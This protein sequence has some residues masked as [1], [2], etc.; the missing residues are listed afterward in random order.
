MGSISHILAYSLIL[1]I[2]LVGAAGA[3]IPDNTTIFNSSK[4]WMVANGADSATLSLMVLNN[5]TNTI[6]FSRVEFS[7]NDPTLASLSDT[8]MVTGSDGMITTQLVGKTISGTVLVY[9]NVYYKINVSDL[10]EQNIIYTYSQKIDHDTPY[11]ISY[12][13]FP[14]GVV[15]VGTELPVTIR[16]R[17][18]WDNVVENKNKA[19]KITFSIQGSPGDLAAF[20]NSGSLLSYMDVYDDSNGN[21]NTTLKVSTLPGMH[22]I[23]VK[24]VDMPISEHPYYIRTIANGLPARITSLV[25]INRGIG[26]STANPPNIVADGFGR[27]NITYT[28]FDQYGNRVSDRVLRFTSNIP[29]EEQNLPAS[30]DM[31]EVKIFYGPKDRIMD[32]SLNVVSIDSGAYNTTLVSFVSGAPRDVNLTANPEMMP[33]RDVPGMDSFQSQIMAKV[34]DGL[35]NAKPG[36]TVTFSLGTSEY[37]PTDV[38]R[39]SEPTFDSFTAVTDNLGYA[40]VNFAPGKFTTDEIDPHFSGSATGRCTVTSVWNGISQ[41]LILTWKNYPYLSADASVSPKEVNVSDNITVTLK[42]KGDGWALY[43]P[44]DIVL[45]TDLAGGIG[46]P[47]LLDATQ[48]ADEAF[49]KNAGNS[50]Y[51]G[52]VSFGSTPP[53]YSTDAWTRWKQQN[54]ATHLPYLFNPYHNATVNKTDYCLLDPTLWDSGLHASSIIV[55]GTPY[56]NTT[57]WQGSGYGYINGYSGATI[58][59][60]LTSMNK[61]ANLLSTILATIGRYRTE[62]NGRGGT[63]YA[64]GINAAIKVF[65]NNPYPGHKKAIIIMGDG[66]PMMAP[67]DPGSLDSYWPSDWYPRENLGWYDESDI[68]IDAA[69]DAADRAKAQ[70]I[71]I[72]AAGFKLGGQ[73]D[74]DTLLKLVSSPDNFYYVPDTNKLDEVLLTIQ[75]RIQNEAGVDTTADLDYGT[76]KVDQQP[77]SGVFNYV[78]Q[79]LASTKNQTYWKN[80]TNIPPGPNYYDQT[81]DWADNILTFDVGTIKVDQVW[82]TSYKLQVLK[83]GTINVFGQ[84]SKISFNNN[85]ANLLLPGITINAHSN[86]SGNATEN[87]TKTL[88]IN[89]L[90]VDQTGNIANLTVD[91][92]INPEE[93][94]LT[95]TADIY[96]TDEEQHKTTWL[97]TVN[98]TP[99]VNGKMNIALIDISQFQLGKQY[100]FY[101]DFINKRPGTNPVYWQRLT[102]GFVR[103]IKPSGVYIRLE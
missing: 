90:T 77:V 58:D 29:G 93:Q 53:M 21:F 8:T 76:V 73:V 57:L 99:V 24:P 48:K 14:L 52:L 84:G 82:E 60:G 88:V 40:T 74:N 54:S 19:E 6:P 1:T 16:L 65:E 95:L 86:S 38:T 66:I 25:G 51:I 91:V 36:E 30:T 67:V 87:V 61:K 71:D 103:A 17:D 32:V 28:I 34:V 15:T 69:V 47:G 9:A 101:V 80:G 41:N 89:N 94:N 10:S 72:Y 13:N 63:N 92:Q 64:A 27:Y 2:V 43:K 42:L 85:T 62:Y 44:V 49:V 37:D 70:G 96:I 56:Y 45:I 75:G 31:G 55:P 81:A 100:T 4:E 5:T 46:G 78:Y 18:Y 3:V 20:N 26:S 98:L 79:P 68:A 12:D 97:Q 22:Q 23:Q 33:S 11:A 83:K 35:G 39:T 7:V 102:S 50:T 59:Q